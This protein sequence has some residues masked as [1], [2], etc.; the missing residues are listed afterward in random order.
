MRI[1]IPPDLK[2]EMRISGKK[3]G[4]MPPQEPIASPQEPTSSLSSIGDTD[5]QQLF[6]SA[7]DGA[8]I[9]D[10]KGKIVDANSRVMSFL[11]YPRLKLLTLSLI[12]IIS[13]AN[14]STL[15]T[16]LTGIEKDRF[17]LI[18]SLIHI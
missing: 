9:T 1:D 16:L 13:G 5:F 6:Q 4:A 17:I 14:D 11:Q 18:L 12:E 8:I 15:S 7:Y 2:E 3:R 10:L